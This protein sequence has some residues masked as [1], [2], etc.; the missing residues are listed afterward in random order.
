MHDFLTDNPTFCT[1]GKKRFPRRHGHFLFL[2][3]FVKIISPKYWI[4]L[5]CLL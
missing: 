2:Q 1:V 5:I 4:F 3:Y